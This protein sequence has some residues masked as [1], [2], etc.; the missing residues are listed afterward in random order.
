MMQINHDTLREIIKY[1]RISIADAIISDPTETSQTRRVIIT[2]HG[3]II[4][5]A[6]VLYPC[7]YWHASVH[8]R[9]FHRLHY[10]YPFPPPRQYSFPLSLFRFSVLPLYL[11]YQ[12]SPLRV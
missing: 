4:K 12:V 2:L 11:H 1:S 3:G 8:Y 7:K 9:L 10:N 6:Q 5:N